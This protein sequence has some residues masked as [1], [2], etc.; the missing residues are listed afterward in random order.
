[1]RLTEKSRDEVAKKL[2]AAEIQTGVHY[3]IPCHRQPAV[4]KRG[5]RAALP[6]TDLVC[7]Q[8]LS[9]PMHP[10]LTSEDVKLVAAALREALK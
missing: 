2:A 8:I 3:P 7:D 1:V 5:P 6:R 9:L 4:T 10:E